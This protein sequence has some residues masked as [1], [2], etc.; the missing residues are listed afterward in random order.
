MPK[1]YREV[2]IA[3]VHGG[4]PI[5]FDVTACGGFEA[6]C[7]VLFNLRDAADLYP[8][9]APKP[10]QLPPPIVEGDV[11][12]WLQEHWS[13][14][15]KEYEQRH[16][17]YKLAVREWAVFVRARKGDANAASWVIRARQQAESEGFQILKLTGP[18]GQL[19]ELPA[20]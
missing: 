6:T 12:D 10:P 14:M 20:V 18:D 1:H 19:I 8:T 11:D 15:E 16:D 4:D 7:Q 3:D 9:E 13:T 2:L 17:K 5:A